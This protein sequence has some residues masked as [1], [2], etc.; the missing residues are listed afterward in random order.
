MANGK[1]EQAKKLRDQANQLVAEVKA[2]E[3]KRID[4]LRKE[5]KKAESDFNSTYGISTG[6]GNARKAKGAGDPKV[7]SN[8]LMDEEVIRIYEHGLTRGITDTKTLKTFLDPQLRRKST[9][10]NKVVEAWGNADRDAKS[11]PERFVA[12][13]ASSGN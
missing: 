4:G 9:V 7:T 8:P 1:I 13:L 11:T 3:R 5:L 6:P 2:E 12:F 10:L